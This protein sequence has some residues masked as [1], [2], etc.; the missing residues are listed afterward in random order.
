MSLF[1]EQAKKSK[2]LLF[3][4]IGAL[5]FSAFA[6]VAGIYFLVRNKHGEQIR[7]PAGLESAIM[8]RL[9]QEV[10]DRQIVDIAYFYCEK[11]QF[12]TLVGEKPS[13]SAVIKMNMVM[14]K[15]LEPDFNDKYKVFAFEKNDSPSGWSLIVMNE[16]LS[17]IS[18]SKDPCKHP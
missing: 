15:S 6:I 13:Y 10:P 2:A 17:F 4:K 11:T 7:P 12:G 3:I 16:S 8:G 14:T 18:K 5:V 9:K 1:E